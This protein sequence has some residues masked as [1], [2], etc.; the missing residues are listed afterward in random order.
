M[1][2]PDVPSVTVRPATPTDLTT[3]AAWQCRY[4]PDGLFPQMGERFVRRWHA[5]FL[6]SPF[7]IALVAERVDDQGAQAVGFLVGST[8]Q[9]RHIDD[10][11]RRHRVRLALAG[12]L[13]LAQ[14]PRLGAHFVRTRGRAY[15]KR[16]LTPKSRRTP[17]AVPAARTEATAASGGQIAVVT[18]IAVDSAARGTG[19]GQELLSR[20]LEDAHTAGATRAELVALLGEGSAAPFYERLN[21]SAVDE[22]PTRDG[23]RARTYRYDLGDNGR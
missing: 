3:M 21:W 17:T 8:D 1:P 20:F 2:A 15:L 14:R 9:F 5:S 11:V 19:A 16:I 13:A 10:V 18:A 6:D 4:V 7:G 22:H 23:M 12:L